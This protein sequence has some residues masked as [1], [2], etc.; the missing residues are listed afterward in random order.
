MTGEA[1]AEILTPA[2]PD[3][4]GPADRADIASAADLIEN[5]SRPVL[6]LGL[7]ASEAN[8]A[9]AVRALL[10]KTQLP[11]VCTYQGA[12]VVPREFF[13][14]FGGR[15]GL[16][17]NQ[18]A[19]ALLDDADLVITIGYY[20][21]E[22]EPSLWNRGR[23]RNIIHIDCS[24]AEIDQDYRPQL[25]LRGNIAA[26]LQSLTARI[27]SPASEAQSPRLREI[28]R[29]RQIFA[30]AAAASNGFPIHPTRL[31]Y[32]L[33]KVMRHDMTV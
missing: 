21:V 24:P 7:L 2:A 15:V 33:Q 27:Q 25:E 11:V 18:L 20:P 26:T 22:Y 10:A 17:H 16:F 3:P 13:H 9:E 12:G 29:E 31:V 8:A 30:A 4:L 6:L 1:D 14:C 32:E 5:A 23:R 28:A 19:D